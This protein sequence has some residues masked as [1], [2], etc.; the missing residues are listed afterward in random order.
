MKTL[1]VRCVSRKGFSKVFLSPQNGDVDVSER[2]V[3]EYMLT[4]D[5]IQKGVADV[6]STVKA[7]IA[8]AK[9]ELC[10]IPVVEQK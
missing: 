4:R 8:E 5:Q 6:N 7:E 3:Y 1:E 2:D 10:C 9:C